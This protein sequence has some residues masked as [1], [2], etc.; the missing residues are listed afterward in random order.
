MQIAIEKSSRADHIVRLRGEL[1]TEDAGKVSEQVHP[2]VATPDSRVIVD[3]SGLSMIDSSG[4]SELIGLATHAR[5]SGSRVI[6]TS[7]TPFVA[8]VLGVT[9]LDRWFEM[10]DS[11]ASAEAL[12][13]RT[14]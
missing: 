1:R 2:L 14:K 4:L 12:L 7:P 10:A 8:G 5:M 6:L 3:L 9:Q 13:G 11:I